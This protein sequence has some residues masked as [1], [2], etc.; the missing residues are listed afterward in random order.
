MLRVRSV[1]NVPTAI[2]VD[3]RSM[4]S[5][6]T[7]VTDELNATRTT[8]RVIRFASCGHENYLRQGIPPA[9]TSVS[10]PAPLPGLS[11]SLPPALLVG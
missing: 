6:A 3:P 1:P 8:A 10:A 5:L 11:L 7:S 9:G 4:A 2:E